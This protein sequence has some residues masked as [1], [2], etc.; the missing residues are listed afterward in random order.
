LLNT[1]IPIADIIADVGYENESFF[2]K[3]FTEKYGRNPS[4]FRKRR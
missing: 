3:K 4:E 2:R 1:D